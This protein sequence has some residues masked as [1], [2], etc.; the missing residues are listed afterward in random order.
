MTTV[1][2]NEGNPTP[3]KALPTLFT[4]PS[5]GRINLTGAGALRALALVFTSAAALSRHITQR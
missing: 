3:E 2:C 1:V 4:L 5:R